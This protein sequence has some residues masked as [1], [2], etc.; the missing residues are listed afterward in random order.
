MH[1]LGP[2]WSSLGGP[3]V[4][5]GIVGL[6]FLLLKSL[7]IKSQ[8]HPERN[9]PQRQLPCVHMWTSSHQYLL[10]TQTTNIEKH[11][12]R[13][14]AGQGFLYSHLGIRALEKRAE[15]PSVPASH[16]HVNHFLLV[17]HM[18]MSFFYLRPIPL[19]PLPHD[20]CEQ[21]CVT[22]PPSRGSLALAFQ[23][24]LPF[25]LLDHLDSMFSQDR[26]P[27]YGQSRCGRHSLT[28]LLSDKLQMSCIFPMV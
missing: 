6:I 3:E 24:A 4:P 10:R 22:P 2:P 17:L 28:C 18:C 15:P 26:L 27:K 11:P 20:Y 13:T 25:C 16:L 23:A 14:G 21:V 19:A 12:V 9:Y 1:S 7:G 5:I 8:C